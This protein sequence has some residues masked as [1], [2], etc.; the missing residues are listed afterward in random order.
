[1]SVTTSNLLLGPATLY[2]GTFGATEPAETA[3]NSTPQASAWT[4][5]G[6]TMDGVKLT[7]DQTYTALEV[8]QIVDRAGSRLTKRDM[9]VE[10]SLAEA[11]L[12]NLAVAM[13]SG[14]AASGA[15]YKSLEPNFA[16]SATQPNYTALLFD[17]WGANSFRR[18]VIV[19]KTLSTDSVEMAYT[20]DKQTV[21]KV[22]FSAHYVSS[23]IAPFH[24]TEAT[25]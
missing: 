15:G 17:G 25:A 6:G 9:A 23:V 8:D 4:D 13:N 22:K 24:I 12:E 10:T 1:M 18:R 11:T 16:S 20:K 21:F 5:M 19:R 2:Q 14:T 7:I 3:V